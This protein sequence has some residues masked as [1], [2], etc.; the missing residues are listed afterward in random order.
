M[1]AYLQICRQIEEL[2]SQI[3]SQLGQH[4]Q[5]APEVRRVF[6]KLSSDERAHAR[7][8]DLVLQEG[9]VS[10][11][12]MARI[13]REKLEEAKLFAEELFARSRQTELDQEQALRIAVKM[14]QK[15]ITVHVQNAVHLS[16]PRLAQLFE[17]LNAADQ[18]HIDSLNECIRWWKN[19]RS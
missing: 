18:E 10:R 6:Q 12:A 16:N 13:S 15:F 2:A 5:F 4:D 11:M 7:N 19:Q 9:E 3:Y 8:L 1:Y 14:E 17:E